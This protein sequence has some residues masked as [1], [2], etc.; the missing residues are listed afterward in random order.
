MWKSEVMMCMWTYF[1]V[2]REEL[3]IDKVICDV[4]IVRGF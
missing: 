2:Y 1:C 4:L 3:N